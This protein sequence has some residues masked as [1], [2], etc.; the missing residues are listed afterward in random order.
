MTKE[1]EPQKLSMG[2]ASMPYFFVKVK[3]PPHKMRMYKRWTIPPKMEYNYSSWDDI[4]LMDNI[5]KASISWASPKSTPF[6]GNFFDLCVFSTNGNIQIWP[7][8]FRA[9]QS[10]RSES[11]CP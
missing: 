7:Y 8:D 1:K 11:C 4:P 5:T 9:N 3:I 2:E 6:T 10:D